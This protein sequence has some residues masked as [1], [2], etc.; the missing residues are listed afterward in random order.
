MARIQ[1]VL[2]GKLA[3]S[4]RFITEDQ[5][6]EC[7]QEQKRLEAAGESPPRLGELL[8]QKGYL[9]KQQ[10]RSILET[11]ASMQ[12]RLFGEIAIGYHFISLE[13]LQ[14]GLD[15]QRFLKSPMDSVPLFGQALIAYR[16]FVKL[17]RD[18]G[19]VPKIGEILLAMGYLKE[20]QVQVIIE[21]QN[22]KI[23]QCKQCGAGLNIGKY[24]E[25][26]KLRCGQCSSVLILQRN[27]FGEIDA[28]LPQEDEPLPQVTRRPTEVR[29]MLPV[30]SGA[31]VAAGTAAGPG[32]RT[33]TSV[34]SRPSQVSKSPTVFGDFTIQ[35]KLGQDSTGTLYKA[36]WAAKQ[37]TVV[38]KIMNQ[39]TMSDA[40]FSKRF[41][42]EAK[43]VA[44]L[45]H[46]NIK[47]VFAIGQIDGRAYMATE[48]V[49]GESVHAILTKQTRL[50][51]TQAL[52]IARK[53]AEALKYAWDAGKIVHGD[54]RPSN[55]LILK[56]GEVMLSGLGIATKTAENILTIAKSGQL[57]PFYLAPEIVTED[58]A[59]DCRSDIYSLGATVYHMIAGRPP[60]QG[61]S[62]FEVLVRL[63]EERV[64]PLKFFDATIPDAVCIV[65]EKMLA[66]EP[67]ERYATYDDV[68]GDLSKIEE[69]SGDVDAS[70]LLGERPSKGRKTTVQ[71]AAVGGAEISVSPGG[72][73]PDTGTKKR[74]TTVIR[75]DS[76]EI[77]TAPTKSGVPIFAWI[78]AAAVV[79][80]AAFF[81]FSSDT[82]SKK[83]ND[84]FDKCVAECNPL[85]GSDR[86]D[87]VIQ[88]WNDFL[89][90]H[91]G[92]SK[93]A[94]VQNRIAAAEAAKVGSADRA[95]EDLKTKIKTTA[96]TAGIPAAAHWLDAGQIPAVLTQDKYKSRV[97]T[98]EELLKDCA[99][100]LFDD[101][102]KAAWALAKDKGDT[103]G[104]RGKLNELRDRLP[105]D[106]YAE[107]LD[108]TRKEL[109][110]WI[111]EDKKH[112]EQL[113]A[114]RHEE[115]SKAILDRVLADVEKLAKDWK[116]EKADAECNNEMVNVIAEHQAV[117]NKAKSDL[118]GLD[119][120][121]R[122]VI[123]YW[124]P[125]LMTNQHPPANADPRPL[126][127]FDQA[128]YR[129]YEIGMELIEM[130]DKDDRLLKKHWGE[131]PAADFYDQIAAPAMKT[132]SGGDDHLALGAVLLRGEALD[133][134]E[135]EFNQA[136][137]LGK[138]VDVY[139]GR[140]E[141]LNAKSAEALLNQANALLKGKKAR[142]GLRV[143][144]ELRNRFGGR[145]FFRDHDAEIAKLTEDLFRG[146]AEGSDYCGFSGA[147][148]WANWKSTGEATWNCNGVLEISGKNGSATL[149][150]KGIS[151][152]QAM[153]QI[154]DAKSQLTIQIG[155]YKMVF[156]P[157]TG[158]GP[159][160][161]LEGR[162]GRNP[163][164]FAYDPEHW[165][166]VRMTLVDGKAHVL[167]DEQ[168]LGMIPAPDPADDLTVTIYGGG[169]AHEGKALLDHL[170]LTHEK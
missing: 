105:S 130:K 155:K 60:Y 8:E 2:F 152:L 108:Q 99:K 150:S 65:V 84:D 168:E 101:G 148:D 49:E 70:L 147:G 26:Q 143:A 25:G 21:E 58:R 36:H 3:V 16:D 72:T 51:H 126:L 131:V 79:L 125:I 69:V 83:E 53:I 55:I 104:A 134:A 43:K 63:T 149:E 40:V 38:V 82:A 137:D 154:P 85:Q 39:A 107:K 120:L 88:K 162:T 15:V 136:K 157:T 156:Q 89:A 75:T 7:L 163:K 73:G 92:T 170:I 95:F 129:V 144:L 47:K 164:D 57:A 76:G 56:T 81:L 87:E 27:Q 113:T 24:G 41:T 166:Y 127:T 118:Q 160:V 93:S 135:K 124:S 29:Q 106:P 132:A 5:L 67:D 45:V 1:N 122:K 20:H 133:R 98:L 13:Q 116:I 94:D 17:A 6:E 80:I 4:T 62:P 112:Q 86:Y 123:E 11:M 9:T 119:Q 32:T 14:T 161:A 37:R 139:M 18:G 77:Q 90:T 96:A 114:K 66:V 142:E 71:L 138:D 140:I 102:T 121:R 54:I 145:K 50:H 46:P 34:T 109:E 167:L 61:Q 19:P 141:E 42:D 169:G 165:Y 97:A 28:I 64:A 44:G 100:Q 117:L 115:E 110:A 159:K 146:A 68:V 59:I 111:E 103:E 78:G 151:E 52:R 128:D 31:P 30:G 10:I 91:V 23:V 48:Y 74:T 33:Q 158:K 22:K 12:R 35:G 153:V